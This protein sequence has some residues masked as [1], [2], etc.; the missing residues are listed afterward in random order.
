[1]NKEYRSGYQ[2]IRDIYAARAKRDFIHPS[3]RPPPATP[4]EVARDKVRKEKERQKYISY[5]GP[6]YGEFKL[7]Q[8]KAAYKEE[9][10]KFR[11][12]YHKGEKERLERDANLRRRDL[13][14]SYLPGR[15]VDYSKPH[16]SP[17]GTPYGSTG[18]PVLN[19]FPENVFELTDEEQAEVLRDFEAESAGRHGLQ[20][21]PL[22]SQY[23][24]SQQEE[25]DRNIKD[26]KNE[27]EP[28]SPLW[29]TAD[30]FATDQLEAQ[31]LAAASPPPIPPG[32]H[33]EIEW[34]IARREE[35]DRIL[36]SDAPSKVK[37]SI[38]DARQ[39]RRQEMEESREYERLSRKE[40]RR[41]FLLRKEDE[42]E[43]LAYEAEARRRGRVDADFQAKEGRRSQVQS[44]NVNLS[45][46][47]RAEARLYINS[48]PVGD[49]KAAGQTGSMLRYQE[50]SASGPLEVPPAS[51]G[52]GTWSDHTGRLERWNRRTKRWD[53]V[54]YYKRNV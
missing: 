29:K 22:Y 45:K 31:R 46:T 37:D 2:K 41:R 53:F 5:L 42:K 26:I 40:K 36:A 10:Q 15:T 47:G 21:R 49:R 14:L 24:G 50:K 16:W 34:R 17:E 25:H 39:T 9:E 19:S 28:E 13:G 4:T 44:L 30:Q 12:D 54:R 38:R 6:A 1:M 7:P 23:R 27:E 20:E 18:H 8:L 11:T 51:L 43:L 52:Y 32:P 35:E 33:G 3:L 48:I